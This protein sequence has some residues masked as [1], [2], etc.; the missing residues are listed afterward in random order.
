MVRTAIA[1][2]AVGVAGV[3]IEIGTASA[4]FPGA[5]GKIAFE[6]DR[7]GAGEIFVM[8]PDGQN[9]TPIASA[10]IGRPAFS[11]DG[12]RIAFQSSADGDFEIF[13]MDADGQ[14]LVQLTSNTGFADSQP[15]F[16]PDGRIAFNSSRTGDE[17]IFVMDADG[18]N[19]TQL[20]F[21]S[22]PPNETDARPAFSPDG[23]RIA[24][25]S[26]RDGD[27]EIFVMDADGQNQTPLTFNTANDDDAT[28][29]PEG[30]RI[31]FTSNRDGPD[32]IFLMDTGGQNQVPLAPDALGDEP[33]FSPDGQSIAFR[34][35][36]GGDDE[37]VVVPAS[38]GA[39]TPL[40]INSAND[41]FPDWQPL[42]PPLCDLSSQPKQKSARRIAATAL[43]QN[44]NAS[45]TV[46]GS[47]RVPKVPAAGAA[48][49]K[50][51]TF[52]LAAIT[53][54]LQPGQA[55]NLELRLPKPAR[56][57]LKAAFE[58]GKKGK[59]TL[60]ATA[61]DDLGASTQD[62]QQVKLKKKKK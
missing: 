37:I 47:L 11:A 32:K 56:K 54:D 28:F 27:N 21:N 6:S 13:V 14:N 26:E 53:A 15:T 17:E 52:E 58:A 23:Q 19:Q 36:L 2:L 9:Q 4:A 50:A 24:F 12:E 62:A 31:A 22:T 7:S 10:E 46:D 18:Q 16:A 42:N 61:T 33:A 60:A 3:A 41:A 25:T 35:S 43:C 30:T 38:G 40:T 29:S 57:R 8:D 34:S 45:L 51:K 44:E 5:N 48:A 39:Q 49:A 20:T 1:V 55:A 59:A